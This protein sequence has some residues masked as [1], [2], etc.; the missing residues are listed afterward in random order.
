MA[1]CRGNQQESFNVL[2]RICLEM[3]LSPIVHMEMFKVQFSI[4]RQRGWPPTM[5][6]SRIPFSGA[7]M[8]SSFYW[9]LCTNTKSSI[10]ASALTGGRWRQSTWY[11][12]TFSGTASTRKD[13]PHHPDQ[14][15]LKC[16]TSKLK[17]IHLKYRQAIVSS[18][19]SGHGRVII[20]YFKLCNQMWGRSPATV[21]ISSGLESTDFSPTSTTDGAKTLAVVPDVAGMT[22]EGPHD[23]EGCIDR[24]E[25]KTDP[26]M[27][28]KP[29][30]MDGAVLRPSNE[31]HDSSSQRCSPLNQQ[32]TYRHQ[33]LKC[34][35]NCWS[36]VRRLGSITTNG[37]RNDKDGQSDDRQHRT[38]VPEYVSAS[39]VADAFAS[40]KAKAQDP[41]S[42]DPSGMP[43][44]A[45][46]FPFPGPMH[47]PICT[48][49][50]HS[51][52]LSI[53]TAWQI[54]TPNDE[55]CPGADFEDTN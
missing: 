36:G 42:F 40:I 52:Q 30:D 38:I 19:K 49:V 55:P 7:T 46:P 17:A 26:L 35:L 11:P 9:H 37:W 34:G 21:Q 28:Q 32:F 3:F 45:G 18:K 23:T 12:H 22:P 39:T 33:K 14:V 8:K 1:T 6:N 53:S 27:S 51:L 10:L 13:Y 50:Y 48:L 2:A 15:T 29:P 16:L 24:E 41:S 54:H 31:D 43:F 5:T 25:E 4:R 44:C 47:P 20:F